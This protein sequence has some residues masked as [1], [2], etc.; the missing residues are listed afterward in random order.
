MMWL[1]RQLR[2]WWNDLQHQAYMAEIISR[3][4]DAV[5]K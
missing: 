5:M 2:D 1:L 3:R 4:R